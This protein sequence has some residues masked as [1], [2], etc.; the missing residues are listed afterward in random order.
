MRIIGT[1]LL[2]AAAAAFSSPSRAQTLSDDQIAEIL[3]KESRDAY[4]RTGHLC[5][6]PEDKNRR[7]A[8]CAGRSAYSQT[9]N[10]NPYCYVADVPKREIEAYRAKLK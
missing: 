5:A 6:C 8:K 4:F 2:V 1:V 9:G 7:G 10:A 3:V